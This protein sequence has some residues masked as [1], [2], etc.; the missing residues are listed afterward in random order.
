MMYLSKKLFPLLKEKGAL[1][2]V[3]DANPAAPHQVHSGSSRNRA[4]KIEESVICIIYNIL[5]I[6]IEVVS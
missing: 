5:I 4:P 1:K 6:L 2:E 3:P